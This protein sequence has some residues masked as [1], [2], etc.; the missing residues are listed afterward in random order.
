MFNSG[1]D[2]FVNALKSFGYNIV[3]LPK[4]DIQPLLLL[5]KNGDNLDRLGTV[6]TLLTPGDTIA[7]P[8]ITSD[9][10]A[11]NL[12]G[13]RTGSMKIGLGLSILGNIIGAMGGNMGVEAQYQQ[14]KSA[15]FEFQSVLQDQIDIVELDQYLGDADI[16][17]ASVFVS[18]LLDAD[19]LYVVTAT[20]KSSKFG[21]E[22]KTSSGAEVK[23][24]V[25]VIQQVVGGNVTVGG[26][27]ATTSKLTYEGKIPLIFGFQAVQLFFD[28]GKYTA[29]KPA[30][31]AMR[32]ARAAVTSDGHEPELFETERT[33][34]RLRDL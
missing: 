9:V 21:F 24:S 34:V 20:I 33:F 7:A 11:A 12:N 26:D 30:S 6:T 28:N 23:V 13:S 16:N 14:A 8:K 19:K 10:S 29:L 18:Q 15:V 5:S 17:P 32:A 3:R 4:A 2:P 1:S 22:A 31:G 27:S 25:P